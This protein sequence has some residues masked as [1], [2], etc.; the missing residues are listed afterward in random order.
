M[1]QTGSS[2]VRR[3]L[4]K[5]VRGILL[6]LPFCKQILKNTHRFLEKC[7]I[8]AHLQLMCSWFIKLWYCQNIFRILEGL[9][10]HFFV[11]QRVEFW[12]A[13]CLHVNIFFLEFCQLVIPA[14]SSSCHRLASS[15]CAWVSQLNSLSS[16]QSHLVSPQVGLDSDVCSRELECELDYPKGTCSLVGKHS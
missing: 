6:S 13:L 1:Y 15:S 11:V 14:L 2:F 4:I 12:S 9:S 5:C 16:D 8:I 10:L 7:W 3:I